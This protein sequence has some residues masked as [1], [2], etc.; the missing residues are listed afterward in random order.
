MLEMTDIKID[1][2]NDQ[3]RLVTYNCQSIENF[4]GAIAFEEHEH[5]KYL[6]DIKT[7]CRKLIHDSSALSQRMQ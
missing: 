4:I 7:G 5:E 6:D 2:R 1:N 3:L